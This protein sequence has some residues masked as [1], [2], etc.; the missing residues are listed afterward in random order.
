MP[1]WPDNGDFK[2]ATMKGC[3]KLIRGVSHR[4]NT[5]DFDWEGRKDPNNP[6][7]QDSLLTRLRN[8]QATNPPT[9]PNFRIWYYPN[10]ATPTACA[11]FQRMKRFGGTSMCIGFDPTQ[12]PP[13]GPSI[14]RLL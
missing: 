5:H 8:R 6:A 3:L 11:C 10:S 14:P 13:G 12:F 7:V 2:N 4:A 9:Y 1:V